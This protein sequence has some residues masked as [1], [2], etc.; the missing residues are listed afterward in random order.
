VRPML[1]ERVRPP[2]AA[3]GWPELDVFPYIIEPA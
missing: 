3:G 1:E 2:L